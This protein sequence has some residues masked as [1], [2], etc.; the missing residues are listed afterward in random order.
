[1]TKST[2]HEKA[3]KDM[4]WFKKQYMSAQVRLMGA[5]RWELWKESVI[6]SL[7]DFV[8]IRPNQ[9]WGRPPAV[10]TFDMLGVQSPLKQ[11]K[12]ASGTTTVQTPQEQEKED[13]KNARK[14]QPTSVNWNY[15]ESQEYRD[16][17]NSI[18]DNSEVNGTLYKKALDILEH[19]Q[20]TEMEDMH[21]IDS[22]TGKI[23]ASQ[24]HSKTPHLVDYNEE[25]KRAGKKY[26][27][28][29]ITIHNHPNSMPPSGA[30]F[31]SNYRR[32]YKLGV[33]I[34]HN[35]D[36]YVYNNKDSSLT[37]RQVNYIFDNYPS[38]MWKEKFEELARD[39]KLSWEKL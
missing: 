21:L 23:V 37:S 15:V 9:S 34:A 8:Y 36:V 12:P 3:G 1:M 33:V 38:Q 5:G 24:T 11:P 35:G 22:E 27:G 26:F 17:F 18:T 32:G 4:G 29:L 39:Y 10:K 13:E 31:T 30:D 25:M 14:N 6:K 16:K 7:S 2:Q 19:R 28:K 20:N